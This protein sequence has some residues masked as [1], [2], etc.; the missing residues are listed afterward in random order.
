MICDNCEH[1]LMCNKKPKEFVCNLDLLPTEDDEC[2]E[3]VYYDASLDD[4][5]YYVGY[6]DYLADKWRNEE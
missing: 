2:D 5:E 1:F 6:Q 3:Y 4:Y